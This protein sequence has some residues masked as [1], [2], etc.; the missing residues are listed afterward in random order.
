MATIIKLHSVRHLLGP[1]YINV[2]AILRFHLEPNENKTSIVYCE[3]ED[4]PN[5][6]KE[7]PGEIWK[8]MLEAERAKKLFLDHGPGGSVANPS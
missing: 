7:L 3:G 1:I 5:F 4:Y 2:D 8:M 6:V